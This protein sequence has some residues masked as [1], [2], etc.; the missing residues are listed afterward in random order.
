MVEPTAEEILRRG[1]NMSLDELYA[2]LAKQMKDPEKV[3]KENEILRKY[4]ENKKPN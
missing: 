2:D 4:F 3:I 1:E